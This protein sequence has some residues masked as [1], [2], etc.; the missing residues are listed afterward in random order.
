ME[1]ANQIKEK[2]GC[3]EKY[4]GEKVLIKSIT[5]WLKLLLRHWTTALQHRRQRCRKKCKKK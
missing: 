4:F 1:L 2:T 3:F 5:L